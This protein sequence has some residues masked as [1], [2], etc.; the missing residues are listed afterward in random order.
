MGLMEKPRVWWF[1]RPVVPHTSLVAKVFDLID[2][3]DEIDAILFAHVRRWSPLH[4]LRDVV[5][6]LQTP[7]I[8]FNGEAGPFAD[9]HFDLSRPESWVATAKVILAFRER[10]AA[11]LGRFRDTVEADW[12]LLAHAYVSGRPLKAHRYPQTPEAICYPGYCSARLTVPVAEDLV[13]RGLMRKQFFD[14]VHECRQCG[15]RRL[16]VREEC[17]ACRSPDLG[18]TDLIHHYHCATLLPE[19]R[20]RQGPALVCPKCSQHLRNYGKDYD[21]P[22]RVQYCRACD[23]TTSEPD[24]GF[25]C[26]D[27]SAATDGEAIRQVD[28][29]SYA[30]TDRAVELLTSKS[31]LM[32]I[33][34]LPTSLVAEIN[35]NLERCKAVAEIR[36]EARSSI[37][38]AKGE[39]TFRKLRQL[40]LENMANYLADNGS[41]HPGE[42]ADYVLLHGDEAIAARLSDLLA[43]S[44]GLLNTRLDPRLRLA[45]RPHGYA[46]E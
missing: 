19:A 24:I 1:P 43:H 28:L 20:F 26:L 36:Y 42:N 18:E 3:G 30:I 12:R 11:M 39:A 35:R 45:Q 8:D 7:I 16:T 34:G 2:E 40:F 32:R 46:I 27:C 15:S 29:F 41:L 31:P 25:V 17:P 13:R 37:I 6:R 21:R 5:G 44:A 14:R 22:G 10:R 4:N 23:E 9:A 38:D 33:A